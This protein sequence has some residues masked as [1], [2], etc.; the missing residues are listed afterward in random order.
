LVE[1]GLVA[2][3][4]ELRKGRDGKLYPVYAADIDAKRYTTASAILEKK[5]RRIN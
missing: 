4:R 1:R 3:T 2:P 5:K